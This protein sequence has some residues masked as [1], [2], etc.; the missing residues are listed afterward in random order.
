MTRVGARGGRIDDMSRRVEY[1][2]AEDNSFAVGRMTALVGLRQNK[3]NF[4]AQQHANHRMR[5]GYLSGPVR[6]TDLCSGEAVCL[7]DEWESIA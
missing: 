7:V 2:E 5:G 4:L 3:S 1:R 6:N